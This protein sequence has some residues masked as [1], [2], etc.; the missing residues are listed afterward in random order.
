MSA[1]ARA[2]R[3]AALLVGA[4][5]ALALAGCGEDASAASAGAGAGGAPPSEDLPPVSVARA[6]R[7]D[8]PL[9]VR[10]VG[11]VEAIAWVVLKP[12]VGG[13]LEEV[14]FTEGDEV[15]QGDLL[16]R[17]DDRPFQAQLRSAEANLASDT[18]MA[19]DA[20]T[21]VEQL[22]RVEDIMT[23]REVQ[24]AQ[25]DADAAQAKLLA[26]QAAVD[27]ARLRVEYCSIKAPIT[28]RT[29]SLSVHPGGVV[30]AEETELVTINQM[31]PIRV[32]FS[33]PEGQLAEIRASQARAPL[34]VEARPA[35]GAP[36]TG[37]LDFI[38]N[39]VD[40][41]TGTVRLMASFA[42]AD[43]ALWPGQFVEVLLT[44][45]VESGAVVVPGQAVQPGQGGAFVYV[46]REDGTVEQR[47]VKVGRTVAG[48]SV[49]EE[50]LAGDETVVTEGQLRL[51]PGVRVS[52]GP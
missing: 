1:P 51:L 47:T 17:L 27:L 6:E 33:V 7:R 15:Q 19:K 18:A 48:Q 22:Q 8:V 29:G 36:A 2:P 11:R 46:L 23:E 38:D 24:R 35:A 50:G 52:V 43:R 37:R 31:A 20:Q 49:I 41:T 16:L 40:V 21:T 44:L 3:A 12:Q 34:A 39:T 42:N 45:A 32:A 28:G 9:Q 5:L 13:R 10:A 4:A 30:K 26:D 25:A 14:R